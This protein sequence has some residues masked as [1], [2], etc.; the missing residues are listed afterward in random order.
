MKTSDKLYQAES[1]PVSKIHNFHH[2][3]HILTCISL[4]TEPGVGNLGHTDGW[5]A[6]GKTVVKE[7]LR[8]KFG[9][10]T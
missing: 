10:S 9:I 2:I 5:H 4:S 8:R 6:E 1:H 7:Q 3:F